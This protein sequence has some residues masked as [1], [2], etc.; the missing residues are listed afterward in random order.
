[1]IHPVI[2]C[3]GAGSRLW[4]LSRR[5]YP[6]QFIPLFGSGSPFQDCLRRFGTDA[7]APP[8]V[9]SHDALRFL[10]MEQIADTGIVP[11][12]VLLEP[13]ARNTAPAI[14]SA[15]LYLEIRG[16]GDALMLAAPSDHL[17]RD[18]GVFRAAVAAGV[19]AAE[20]GRLVTFGI[21]PTR[22][23]T[24]YGYL[25]TDPGSAE[26]VQPV[27]V[28]RF[29]EKPD[30]DT[31]A[32]MLADGRY[33]WNAGIFLFRVRTLIAAFETHAPQIL[34]ACR[35]AVERAEPDLD[36][37]RLEAE[38]FA[39]APE[40]SL[41]YAIME[42]A[43]DVVTVPLECGWSD[44]GSWNEV[45]HEMAPDAQGMAVAGAVTQIGCRDS[46]LRSEEDGPRLVG[47]NLTD[48]AVI[49]M[50]DAVLVADMSDLQAVKTAVQRLT[51]DGVPE[52]ESLPR[53][54]RPWGWYETLA[55]GARFQVKQ[56]VVPPGRK[57]SLQSHMHRAEHWIVV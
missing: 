26:A 45:W 6:K 35:R 56:I 52:A 25:E 38:A 9:V 37:L 15:A 39:A 30:A 18:P 14:L 20:A 36:F 3:G 46:L 17:I 11:E 44:L 31:A 16:R 47:V 34:A 55:Q 8:L 19:A 7:F 10:A 53:I 12:A 1:M 27:A 54:Y 41:D 29:V 5:A 49:A 4:P 43:R 42:K 50:R 32:R 23:E 22:A 51:A 13:E 33:L 24:G 40:D 21:R 48:T 2:L 28:R 57:L